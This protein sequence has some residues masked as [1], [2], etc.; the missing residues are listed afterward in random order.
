M[1]RI[2]LR[3]PRYCPVQITKNLDGSETEVLGQ[4]KIMGKLV[5]AN[6]NINANP[7][8]V[9]GDDGA[10][11]TVTEFTS[12]SIAP[13]VVN[14]TDEAEAELL[15]QNVTEGGVIISNG[16]DNPPY[17]RQGYIV[18]I[19]RSNQKKYR[20][21]CYMRVKYAPP[22]ET[23]NTKGEQTQFGT[24]TLNGAIMRN[25]DGEW[26]R[27]KTFDNLPAAINWLN[28]MTNM[29]TGPVPELAL[30]SAPQAD[31]D[32]VDVSAA[33][34]LT[35]SN[36]INSGNATLINASTGTPVAVEKGWSGNKKVLT[37]T[38]T[39][40]LSAGTHHQIVVTSIMDAYG[41]SLPDSVIGFT[42][43]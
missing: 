10:A 6:V 43:A 8:T 36:V 21:D 25:C 29:P 27:R 13:E 39:E 38:P 26:R 33:I 15:G 9:Y 32:D 22:S 1:A 14:I 24:E 30:S 34:V 7:Q 18:P 40:S 28:E 41:Q 4:G 3:Y 2:G 35:F 23:L 42:T 20:V 17:I 5:S 16:D 37:L 31:S 19:M 11:E 12:G